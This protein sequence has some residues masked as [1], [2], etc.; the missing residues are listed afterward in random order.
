MQILKIFL[1]HFHGDHFLGLPG[2]IQTMQLNDRDIP[3]HIYGP[4]G[5]TKLVNQL[6]S[7]GYFK[8]NYEI[9]SHELDK[10]DVIDFNE[11]FIKVLNVKHGVPTIAYALEEKMRPGKFDKPKA[12]KLGIPEGPLFSKLQRG[13]TITLKDGKN[14]KPDMVLGSP[15]NGRKIV[16]SGDTVPI[17]KMIDF[18]KGADILIHEATFNSTL[19]DVSN[20]YGHTTASEAAEIAKKANVDKLFLNHISPRYLENHVLEDEARK[21]F[22]N[23]YVPKDFQEIEVKLKN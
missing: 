6:L 23:T 7:L 16:I 10:G 3:L 1:T 21:V 15:R 5:I 12:I 11:Y 4:K 14:I 13:E 2:L 18:S 8:P 9:I 19:G 22:K 20:E 17:K